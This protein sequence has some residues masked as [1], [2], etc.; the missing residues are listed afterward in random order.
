M[1][2]ILIAL[3][4]VLLFGSLMPQLSFGAQPMSDAQVRET[5]V[6]VSIASY[7]GTCPCPYN[8][9]RNGRRCGN[10]SAYSKPG[11]AAPLCFPQDVT[12]AMIDAFRRQVAS[13]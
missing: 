2:S 11:G 5:L 13:K 10:F 12:P 4:A 6:A 7:R 9:M 1:K 3:C 8:I